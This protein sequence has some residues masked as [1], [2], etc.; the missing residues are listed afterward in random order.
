LYA[1]WN[2]TVTY[3][4]NGAAATAPTAVLTTGSASRTF[5]LNSGTGITKPNLS[6]TGWNTKADGSGVNYLG[7]SSY[8]ATGDITLYAIFKPTYTYSANGATGGTVPA[9][10]FGPAP[11]TGCIVDAGYTNCKTFNYIGSNQSF[12]VPS[13]IDATAGITIE[14]WGAGG[15]GTIAY[16]GDPSGG[17]GGYSKA[18]FNSP[19]AGDVLTVVVGQG[20]L[21]KDST[22]QYGGGGA[23]ALASGG[24]TSASGGGYSGIFAGSGTTTPILISGGGGGASVAADSAG[25]TG[26]GGGANQSGGQSA[27]AT[28]GGRGGTISAGGAGATSNNC[29]T[30]GSSLQGGNGCA[31]GGSEGGGGG[32]GGYFGGGGGAY[33]TSTSGLN[34]GGGGGSGYLNTSVATLISAAAGS[35]GVFANF[36]FPDRT[37]ANYVTG[38]GV[39]GKPNTNTVADN[40]GGH[41]LITIQ[42][43]SPTVESPV[44][45]NTGNLI[46]T[47]YTFA[48]WNTAADGSGTSVAVGSAF[49]SSVSTTLYAAWTPSNTGL[50]PNFKADTTAPIGVLA[51]TGY[52]INNVYSGTAN[53][54]ILTDYPDKIQIIASVPSGTLAI[55]TTTNLTLPVGYQS[56]LNTAAATISFVG[57][58]ADVNAAMATL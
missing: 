21:V 48:G 35:N 56:A 43:K 41:G 36:A 26:G 16:Y 25:L 7:S 19:T 46:R 39:G 27:N 55:T 20:G 10:T 11:G 6:F 22:T 33:Q 37:S 32:G 15:G 53:D 18:K 30:A 45:D 5:N 58:L 4:S 14:A 57:N 24:Y 3:N 31:V 52:V 34:G 2:A 12:T 44:A 13:D 50:T 1:Q 29:A 23:A 54:L 8:T 51:S 47:G 49:P 9:L 40:S 42:W 38:I 28:A 17:A